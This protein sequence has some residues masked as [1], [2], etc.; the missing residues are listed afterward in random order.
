MVHPFKR[1][2]VPSFPDTRP[3]RQPQGRSLQAWGRGGR[4]T[5]I[6]GTDGLGSSGQE[7][8]SSLLLLDSATWRLSIRIQLLP[9]EGPTRPKPESPGTGTWKC[10]QTPRCSHLRRTLDSAFVSRGRDRLQS[11]R[12]KETWA[13][14]P[15]RA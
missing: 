3:V 6:W 4:E 15:P 13:Q 8:D 7:P 1:T 5:G 12:T 11:V 2:H 9:P 10:P 14:A